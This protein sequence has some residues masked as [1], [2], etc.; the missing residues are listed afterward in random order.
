MNSYRDFIDGCFLYQVSHSG[1][2]RGLG[3]PRGGGAL[4]H[5]QIG[6]TYEDTVGPTVEEQL[7][8]AGA[9]LAAVFNSVW[10]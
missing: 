10:P 2:V 9:R 6:Q 4:G 5:E 7:A 8:K 1:T 3:K